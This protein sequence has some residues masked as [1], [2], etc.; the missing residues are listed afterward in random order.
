MTPDG[1]TEADN[2]L[3]FLL[4]PETFDFGGSTFVVFSSSDNIQI[5]SATDGNVWLARVQTTAGGAG[6]SAVRLNSR[7]SDREDRVRG[8]VEVYFSDTGTPIWYY[9]EQVT[10][11]GPG[12]IEPNGCPV[13]GTQVR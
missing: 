9:S 2:G 8:E 4:S 3:D 6:V 5:N 10:L 12:G 7:P 1:T 11:S 13:F